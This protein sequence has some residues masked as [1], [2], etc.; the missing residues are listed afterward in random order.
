M[1]SSR[2]PHVYHFLKLLSVI[3]YTRFLQDMKHKLCTCMHV[4]VI[5]N[6]SIATIKAV[7]GSELLSVPACSLFGPAGPFKRLHFYVWPSPLIFLAR[8]A[9]FHFGDFKLSRLLLLF[10]KIR[11]SR[12]DNYTV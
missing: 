4:C 9:P 3:P 5:A 6:C 12:P 8:P 11:S 7:H 2:S 1:S 10:F